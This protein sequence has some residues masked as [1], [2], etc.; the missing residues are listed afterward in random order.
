MRAKL[1]SGK[2]TKTVLLP[3]ILAL[4]L[5]LAGCGNSDKQ[6]RTPGKSGAANVIPGLCSS[7]TSAGL[8]KQCAVISHER[9]VEVTI[10]SFDDE[11]ARNIC[12][13]ITEE[14]TLLTAHLS[15]QWKLQ[16][17]SPYRSDKPLASCSLH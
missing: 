4:H 13:K 8:A 7:I 3:A 5:P 17:L 15:G 1:K 2:I 16:V 12:A 6:E 9:L 14:T 10:D 11:K